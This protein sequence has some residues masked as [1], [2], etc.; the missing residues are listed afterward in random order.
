MSN[1]LEPTVINDGRTEINGKVYMGDGQGGF[2][3]IEN[4]KPQHLIED[5]VV[6]KILGFAIPLSEQITRFKEHTFDDI[7]AHEAILAQEYGAKLGGKKGNKTLQTVDGLFRVKVR[8]SDHLEFGP[9][10]QTAKA[11]FDELLNEWSEG[12]QPELRALIVD[13]FKT[14]QAGNIS[15]GEIF[16][17]LR[18][19][20]ENPRFAE[21]Q[22]AT[23]DAMRIVGS[24]MYLTCHRRTSYDAP[25]EHVTISLAQA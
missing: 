20:T 18:V 15:R 19:P 1:A 7:G 2:Q 13:A 12:S 23:R 24:K 10:L 22:R 4:I 16:R 17:L 14:D 25:W 6:R 11:L 3:P 21:A 9:E 8:I 5:E